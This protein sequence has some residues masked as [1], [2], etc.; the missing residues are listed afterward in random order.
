ML[1]D[2]PRGEVSGD[3]GAAR[4]DIEQHWQAS[5]TRGEKGVKERGEGVRTGAGKGATAGKGAIT[6]FGKPDSG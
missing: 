4:T 3:W 6:D 1:A 5:G 2:E